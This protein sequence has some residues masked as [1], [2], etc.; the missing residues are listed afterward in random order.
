M[1]TDMTSYYYFFD[2][3]LLLLVSQQSGLPRNTSVEDFLSLV[4]YGDIPAP[5]KDLLSKC[6]FP[7]QN[8]GPATQQSAVAFTGI[9]KSSAVPG[10]AGAAPAS[11]GGAGK[12]G[13]VT[14]GAGASADASGVKLKQSKIGK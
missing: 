7:Q 12:R 10:T 9:G 8:R 1:H 13:R 11:E 4:D 14:S 5:D 3:L 2:I 6:V